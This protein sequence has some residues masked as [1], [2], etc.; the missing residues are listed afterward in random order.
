[1]T[2]RELMTENPAIVPPQATIAQ[3]WDLM[4]ELDI[5]HLPVVEG[6][7]V[8]GMLSDRDVGSLD[9]GRALTEEGADGLR[10]RLTRPV[11]QLMSTD[12]VAAE[13]ETD[14]SELITLFLEQKVGAIPVVLA[15][16]QQLVGIVSYIDILR[17]VQELL[18][19]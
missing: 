10:R 17:A 9:V 3:A 5:R 7:V 18:A 6:G 11:S 1:M 19:D 14:V 2:A 4:R 12:V 15:D 16:S 8:V 13:P